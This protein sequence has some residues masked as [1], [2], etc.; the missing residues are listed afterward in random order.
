MDSN[1]KQY[2]DFVENGDKIYLPHFTL[3]CV[4]FGY[5][6]K[7]L[8]VLLTK[9]VGIGWGVP[10]GYVKR[11][12][13]LT[14]AVNRIL[15]ERTA[16]DNIFLK[17]FHT[18]GDSKHRIKPQEYESGIDV[19]M[20]KGTWLAERTLSIGYYALM[21][22]SEADI[23]LDVFV[24]DYKW[25][26]VNEIPKDLLLDHN[27]I[28]DYALMTLRNQIFH[29]PIG[30]ELL[31]EKFTLPE[32]QTLYETILNKKFDRRNF[33]NKLL[34]QEIIVKLD[35]KRNIGQHRSP[36]LYKFHKENYENALSERTALVL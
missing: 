21:D 26:D 10:S 2:Y 3:E 30:F 11:E 17:Q 6:N 36:F 13:S 29:E 18:F 35:E 27:E 4:I 33:P 22:C 24:E 16:L 14:V 5:E 9:L 7:Q 23:K 32:I 20:T 15:K 28:I 12:E 31:P 1:L 19:S 8:K 34:A 25:V